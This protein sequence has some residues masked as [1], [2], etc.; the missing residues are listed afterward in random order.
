MGVQEIRWV[1]QQTI[2]NFSVEMGTTFVHKLTG[3]AVQKVDFVSDMMQS[4]VLLRGLL[5][6]LF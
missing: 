1:F 3:V 2:T 5:I 4:Y 6:L